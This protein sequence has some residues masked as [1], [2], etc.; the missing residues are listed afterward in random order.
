MGNTFLC[1]ISGFCRDVDEIFGLLEYYAELSGSS[2]L[3]FRDNISVSSSRVKKSKTDRLSR[4][5]GK[6]PPLN[7]A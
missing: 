3:T 4:N 1:L 2:V 5:V 6:E 7:A